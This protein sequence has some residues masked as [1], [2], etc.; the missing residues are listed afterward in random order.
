MIL[1]GG[2]VPI[3][4]AGEAIFGLSAGVVYYGALYYA[5]VV[6]NASVNACGIH[7]ALLGLALVIG[8]GS[9]LLSKALMPL[10]GNVLAGTLLGIAPLLTVCISRSVRALRGISLLPVP[11]GHRGEVR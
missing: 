9:G 7:E 11:E 2:T 8:P 10:T 5:M 3:V 1:F 4:I 6:K